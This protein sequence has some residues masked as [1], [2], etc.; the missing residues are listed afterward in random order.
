MEG[1]AWAPLVEEAPLT[2]T[3]V[4]INTEMISAVDMRPLEKKET[5]VTIA[6]KGTLETTVFIFLYF[7]FIIEKFIVFEKHSK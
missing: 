4:H 1:F 3:E 6:W 2:M 7:V 5:V